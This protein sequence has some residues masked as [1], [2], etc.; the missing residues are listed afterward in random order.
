MWAGDGGRRVVGLDHIEGRD[1]VTLLTCW[2]NVDTEGETEWRVFWCG[3]SP[4]EEGSSAD[5]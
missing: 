2:L 1:G 3:S 5:T 4:E